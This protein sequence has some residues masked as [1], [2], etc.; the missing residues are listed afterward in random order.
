MTSLG[1]P[2]DAMENPG[3]DEDDEDTS[4]IHEVYYNI[5]YYNIYII[6]YIVICVCEDMK[7]LMTGRSQVPGWCVGR[8]QLMS[9]SAA[10]NPEDL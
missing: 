7:Y 4:M 8:A 10:G 1:A 2:L 3:K 6:I 5:L 9:T